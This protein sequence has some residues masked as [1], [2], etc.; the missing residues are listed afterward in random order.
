MEQF[1][2]ILVVFAGVVGDDDTLAQATTLAKRNN[3]RMTVVE[4]I[5]DLNLTSIDIAEKGKLLQRLTV[6]IREEGIRVDTV[7][8]R[9]TP[10]LEI[11]RQVLL[12]KHDLVM[13]TAEGDAGYKSL[14]LGSTSFHLMRKCPCPV[15]VTN[16]E[17][18]NNYA[19]IMA[20]I[21]P[22]L[23]NASDSALN[24]KIMDLATSQ[25]RLNKSE[26]FIVQAWEVTGSDGETLQSETTKE[27]RAKIYSKHE[28][29]YQKPLARFLKRYKLN[30]INH[31]IHLLRGAPDF[32]IPQLADT[33]KVDLIVMGT[34]CRTGISGFFIG[35]TAESILRQVGCAVLTVKP[36][37]FVTPV[38]MYGA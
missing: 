31:Q 23:D 19:R 35:N 34:I 28:L 25:A 18:K 26:L 36:E 21:E 7:M 2:N 16:P 3:A 15:W 6:S 32:V 13:M 29:L 22:E 8:R 30:D 37:G 4:V 33:I 11:I 17:G 12:E 27:I 38:T 9:G 1:K 14:F 20:A 10:F 5:K 24:I